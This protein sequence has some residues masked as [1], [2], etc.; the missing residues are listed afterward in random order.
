MGI[1]PRNLSNRDSNPGP[2][3]S[4]IRVQPTEPRWPKWKRG[5]GGVR[6]TIERYYPEPQKKEISGSFVVKGILGTKV[7]RIGL[8]AGF[9]I[10]IL[11]LQKTTA[12]I[13]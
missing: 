6:P 5:R 2:S 11:A 3:S 13:G 9:P 10:Y 4:Q 12:D 1:E 8:L 7:L